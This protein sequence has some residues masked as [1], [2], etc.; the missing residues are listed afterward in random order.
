[1]PARTPRFSFIKMANGENHVWKYF[2]GGWSPHMSRFCNHQNGGCIRSMALNSAPARVVYYI[3]KGTNKTFNDIAMTFSW[4]WYWT[5]FGQGVLVKASQLRS[6]NMFTCRG[7]HM[8]FKLIPVAR[9]KILR[10]KCNTSCHEK[11]KSL[12]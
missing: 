8:R 6:N 10:F 3:L 7:C 9:M 4:F 5:L 1:M 11:V 12:V 2:R